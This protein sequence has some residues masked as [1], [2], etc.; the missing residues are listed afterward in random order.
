MKK[1]LERRFLPCEVRAEANDRGTIIT[2]RP[3]VYDSRTDL[4]VFDE[5]IAKDA[6]IGTDLRDVRFLV[7]HDFNMIPLARSRRNNGNSTMTLFVDDNGLGFEANIDTEN[8][9]TARELYSAVQ[10][11]D[12]SGMSF[13]FSVDGESWD[14]IKSEHPLRTITS[15]ASIVEISA[16]TF[17][18]YEATSINARSDSEALESARRALEK[19]RRDAAESLESERRTLELLKAKALNY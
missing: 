15:I 3:V 11:G 14:D 7:N 12:V 19:A 6:L 10:R 13:A 17:P 16:V 18:A 2:G 9:A 4:G 8:N 5:I 1:E